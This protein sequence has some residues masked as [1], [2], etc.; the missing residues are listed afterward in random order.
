MNKSKENNIYNKNQLDRG[1]SLKKLILA[2]RFCEEVQMVDLSKDLKYTS[3]FSI[4]KINFKEIL[5]FF[6][7]F[8]YNFLT[9]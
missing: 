1:M 7:N 3:F 4:K 6:E 9:F 2:K 5:V 8:V